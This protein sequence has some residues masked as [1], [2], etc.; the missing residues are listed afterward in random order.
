MPRTTAVAILFFLPLFSTLPTSE[1]L[2]IIEPR[3]TPSDTVVVATKL[4]LRDEHLKQQQKK[5]TLGPLP[6]REAFA[7]RDLQED[8][9]QTQTVRR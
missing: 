8:L 3:E 5:E 6:W 4:Y 1:S 9:F 2:V 7:L